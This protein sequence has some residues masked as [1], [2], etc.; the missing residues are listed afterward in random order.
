MKAWKRLCVLSQVNELK[1]LA[2]LQAEAAA[3]AAAVENHSLAAVVA[4]LVNKT[5]SRIANQEAAEANVKPSV[6]LQ[7]EEASVR[8]NQ[9]D[10]PTKTEAKPRAGMHVVENAS[11]TTVLAAVIALAIAAAEVAVEIVL[12]TAA[13]QAAAENALI[14]AVVNVQLDELALAVHAVTSMLQDAEQLLLTVLGLQHAA[15]P[16]LQEEL[17]PVVL[18][19]AKPN[20]VDAVDNAAIH[21]LAVAISRNPVDAASAAAHPASLAAA[22]AA[23]KL[24]IQRHMR[25]CMCLFL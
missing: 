7:A 3:L 16:I 15:K 22:D 23:V 20:L 11:T 4:V 17:I 1:D 13:A 25:V 10:N 9:L 19:A 18:F 8:L 14:I 21:Q 24:N 6:P 5:V 12:I 2:A